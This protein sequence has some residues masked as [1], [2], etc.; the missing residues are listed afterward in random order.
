MTCEELGLQ[1]D[2]WQT[3]YLAHTSLTPH[4]A[5]EMKEKRS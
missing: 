3:T 1:W 2:T 4:S 5:L